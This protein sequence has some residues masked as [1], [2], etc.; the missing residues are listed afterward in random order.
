MLLAQ[1]AVKSG[2]SEYAIVKQALRIFFFIMN[3]LFVIVWLE[4]SVGYIA[5]HLVAVYFVVGFLSAFLHV[6]LSKALLFQFINIFTAFVVGIIIYGYTKYFHN[7]NNFIPSNP[8]EN[9]LNMCPIS[10]IIGCFGILLC[11][12]IR[13]LVERLQVLYKH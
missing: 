13:K 12:G 3:I 9:F 8:F 5:L 7:E 6:K 4:G 1:K 2:K 10:L 11:F